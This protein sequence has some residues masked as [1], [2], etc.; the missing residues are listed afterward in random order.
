MDI[1]QLREFKTIAEL[2]SVSRAAEV[3]HVAQPS[4]SRTI[5]TL[6]AELNISLF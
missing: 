2:Q 3:L 1:L 4:L 6:E 5:K